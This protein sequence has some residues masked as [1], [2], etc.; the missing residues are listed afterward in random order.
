MVIV[1]PEDPWKKQLVGFVYSINKISNEFIPTLVKK[2][3]VVK[4]MKD[5]T[6]HDIVVKWNECIKLL[7]I[8]PDKLQKEFQRG[9]NHA[10]V[11]FEGL[12][13]LHSTKKEKKGEN[14]SGEEREDPDKTSC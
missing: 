13:G 1:M 11:N 6:S 5:K 12:S 8:E 3:L 4:N 10:L 7:K 2:G 14:T 9:S